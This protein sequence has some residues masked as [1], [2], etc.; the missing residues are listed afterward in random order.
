MRVCFVSNEYYSTITARL[1]DV[2]DSFFPALDQYFG[3]PSFSLFQATGHQ[4]VSLCRSVVE[5][6]KIQLLGPFK[7]S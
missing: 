6:E 5:E 2:C 3:D 7:T 1:L 4:L